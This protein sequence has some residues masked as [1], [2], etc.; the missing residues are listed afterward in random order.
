MVAPK[1]I[2]TTARMAIY[3]RVSRT[4]TLLSNAMIPA[5]RG[6]C[7]CSLIVRAFPA[8]VGLA[9]PVAR[10]AHRLDQLDLERVVYL[11]PQAAHVHVDHVGRA[12]KVV[13]PDVRLHHI[14][15]DEA[16]GVANEVF[17]EGVLFG[18]QLKRVAGP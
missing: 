3:Q 12:L 4:R 7:H 6:L 5:R 1:A 2:S 18:R 13:A 11:A 8:A 17:E 16:V 10:P 15:G 9:E 14:A